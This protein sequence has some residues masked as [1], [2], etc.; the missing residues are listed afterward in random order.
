MEMKRLKIHVV[1]E[2]SWLIKGNGVNT[3]YRQMVDMLRERDDL[4]VVLNWQGRGD[5]Y[6]AHSYGLVYFLRGIGYKGRRILTVHVI[7]DTVRGSIPLW[8]L[9]MPAFRWYFKQVY[10]YADVC[11]AISPMVEKVVHDLSPGTRIFN[12]YNPLP[13]DYWKRT[14][15]LRKR[16][17]EM[18]GLVGDR[19]VILGVGQIEGRKGVEDFIDIGEALPE[20]AFVWAGGRPFGPLTEG[21]ARINSRIQKA[22]EHIKFPG[23]LELKDMPPIYAA[24]DLFLFPSIQENCPMAP[25][26]AAASGIPVIFRD[27]PEYRLLYEHPYLAAGNNNEFISL[28]RKMMSDP[29][30]YTQGQQMSSKLLKQFDKGAITEKLVGLYRE[31]YKGLAN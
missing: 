2:L 25:L 9:T 11:I 8:Q 24:A 1:S 31:I 13:V 10:R 15:E 19:F 6:H 21:L 29:E 28:V 18:L 26:E 12:L 30:F 20:A 5:V 4:E 16:G 17:R 22:P 23:M 7:P 27:L 3:A 14:P